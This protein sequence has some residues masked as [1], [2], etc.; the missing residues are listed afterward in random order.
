MDGQMDKNGEEEDFRILLAEHESP[1]IT[2]IGL[3]CAF[4]GTF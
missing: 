3:F 4:N 1:N 2:K